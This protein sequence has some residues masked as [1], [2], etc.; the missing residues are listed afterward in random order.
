[1]DRE[2]ILRRGK[3]APPAG[4][5]ETLLPEQ[6]DAM[7]ARREAWDRRSFLRA[8]AACGTA[9]LLAG[10]ENRAAAARRNVKLG[11][12]N[13]SIRAF[14]WKAPQLIEYA[15]S[16]KVDTLFISDLGAYESLEADY[17]ARIREKAERCG[18][19]LHAGTG[20][21]CPTSSAYQ[22]DRL[23]PPED[24]LRLLIRVAKALGSPVARCYL[25]SRR[26]RT[27]E[28]G[29][30]R[31][32]EEMVKVCKAVRSEA[33]D[34]G[35]KIAIENHAGDM[36]AWELV[37][38]IEAAGKEYVGATLDSGNAAWT[39]E[40]P[41]VNL[42]ILGPHAVTTGM[43]DTALWETEDGA[44]A[45]WV[46][47]GEGAVDWKAYVAR[48]EALCPGVPFVLEILSYVWPQEFPFL[49]P[50]MWDAFPKARAHEFARFVAL[51]KRG[52]KYAIPAGRPSGDRSR[53]IEQAQQKFDLEKSIAYAREVLG[54]GLKGRA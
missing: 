23:G 13:F 9:S 51:V 47:L 54:L 2:E 44:G 5:V 42:E 32:I 25:G 53:D 34:A 35:V 16:L 28:G 4:G 43:R 15:A 36:Q 3:V 19:E 24:H 41:M 10:G 14:G 39:L 1:M 11:F 50:K 6:E 30:Y 27:G 21:I 7:E 8:M 29:I 38:L 12:D 37:N 31:H 45:I 26:E 18:I 22:R 20:S 52:K 48:F 33:V 17:L 49:D 46:N 40:D